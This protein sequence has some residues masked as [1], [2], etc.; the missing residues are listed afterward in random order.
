M[1]PFGLTKSGLGFV[2]HLSSIE[3]LFRFKVSRGFILSLI[4]R[5]N[6]INEDVH[7]PVRIP[8]IIKLYINVFMDVKY[9][10]KPFF[11]F[12]STIHPL[13]VGSSTHN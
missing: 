9:Y 12:Y 13:P 5:P 8:I 7:K 4:S 2:S 10:L 11:I 3:V 6:K 1:T